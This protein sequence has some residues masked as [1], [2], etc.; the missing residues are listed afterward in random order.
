MAFTPLL[1]M[2]QE[3]APILSDNKIAYV[4]NLAI[5]H[6]FNYEKSKVHAKFEKMWKDNKGKNFRGTIEI[7]LSCKFFQKIN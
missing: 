3:R 4:Y 2:H 5:Q 1:H 7:S 6:W